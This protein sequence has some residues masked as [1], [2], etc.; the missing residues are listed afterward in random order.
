MV[1]QRRR[2]SSQATREQL[3]LQTIL[4]SLVCKYLAGLVTHGAVSVSMLDV[5]T[6][7]VQFIIENAADGM[8]V[9]VLLHEEVTPLGSIHAILRGTTLSYIFPQGLLRILCILHKV[10]LGVADVVCHSSLSL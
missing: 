8:T 5:V 10:I 3:I 1:P 6:F 2:A 9:I 7:R 4:I